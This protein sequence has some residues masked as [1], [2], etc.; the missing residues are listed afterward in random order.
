MSLDRD[1]QRRSQAKYDDRFLSMEKEAREWIEQV[2]G[3]PL[4]PAD[5][6][7]C[8]C[9]KDGVALCKLVNKVSPG[10]SKYKVSSMPFVQMENISQFLAF[11]SRLGMPPHDSFQTIDLYERKNVFQVIQALHTFSRFAVQKG[12]LDAPVLGPKLATSRTMEFTEEQL[13]EAKNH[14]NTLQYGK[15]NGSTNVLRGSRRD[16]AGNFH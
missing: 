9:L 12:D 10:A 3:E 8:D 11:A 15:H 6:D 2:L 4:L 5:R 1:L 16:P 14:F 7:L 13:R